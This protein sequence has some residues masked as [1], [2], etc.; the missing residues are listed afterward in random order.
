[1]PMKKMFDKTKFAERL[2]ALMNDC[3]DTTYALG[4]HLGLSPSLISRY[5]NGEHMA[6]PPTIQMMATKYNVNP[7]WLMGADVAKHDVANLKRAVAVPLY[8]A[9]FK[10]V[11]DYVATMT[12]DGI[13]AATKALDDSMS[14]SRIYAGD[15]VLVRKSSGISSGNM[16]LIRFGGDVLI[17]RIYISGNS[18][19]LRADNAKHPDVILSKKEYARVEM[20]GE[21]M[22]V[23]FDVI[24]SD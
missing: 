22:S 20:L 18:V 14:G 7:V 16:Y 19:F 8:D 10:D 24:R 12:G 21:V 3:G 4:E 15:T 6:K 5:L 9:S 2:Q 1:M 17:R 23:I 13:D 11:I